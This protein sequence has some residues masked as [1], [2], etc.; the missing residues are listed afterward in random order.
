MSFVELLM[1]QIRESAQD[2]ADI[3]RLRILEARE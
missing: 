2:Q 1:K 3:E